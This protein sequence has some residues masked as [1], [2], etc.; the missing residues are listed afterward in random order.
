MIGKKKVLST[1]EAAE[2]LGIVKAKT[3]K[4]WRSN[5]QS[6]G[7]LWVQIERNAGYRIEDLDAYLEN[8]TRHPSEGAA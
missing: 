6:K 1:D 5:R 7:P 8:C 2:Y 3:L 4:N